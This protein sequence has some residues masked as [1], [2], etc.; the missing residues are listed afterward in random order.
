MIYALPPKY[1]SLNIVRP[2]NTV[3]PDADWYTGLKDLLEIDLGII[4]V[5]IKMGCFAHN[6]VCSLNKLSL[7]I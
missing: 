1:P 3:E 7:Q 2:M 5:W 4:L 6:P